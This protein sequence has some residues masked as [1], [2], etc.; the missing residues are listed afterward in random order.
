MAFVV[1]VDLLESVG[2]FGQRGEAEQPLVIRQE[3]AWPG[4]LHD[5]RFAASEVAERAVADPGVLEFHARPLGTTELAAR[6][7]EVG[8]IFLRRACDFTGMSN[9]PAQAFQIA[10]LLRV[11]LRSEVEGQLE[12]LVR[13]IRQVRELQERHPLGVLVSF[14]P[15]HDPVV[16][17]PIG[18]GR[19]RFGVRLIHVRPLLQAN[20][21]A[22]VNPF[23]PAIWKARARRADSLA[24]R[25]IKIVGRDGKLAAADPE[26]QQARIN[27]H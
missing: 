15:V 2:G 20:R 8:L 18:N 24:G 21:R 4:V 1:A 6:L 27:V 9:A 17:V 26:L 19:E 7:L 10:P 25:E 13:L 22:N 11:L 12:R 5:R 3:G 23:Q 16:R 14:L